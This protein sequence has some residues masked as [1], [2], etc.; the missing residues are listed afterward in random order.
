MTDTRPRG[1]A[2]MSPERRKEIAT[3]GGRSVP[4][5]KRYYNNR[6]AASAAGKKGVAIKA[7]KARQV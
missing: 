2:A 7:Y 4:P 5:E 1:F 3:L 6:A